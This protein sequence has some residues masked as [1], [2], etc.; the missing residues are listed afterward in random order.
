MRWCLYDLVEEGK[1]VYV[2]L[3]CRPRRRFI[4]HAKKYPGAI[5]VEVQWH[6]DQGVG[7]AAEEFRIQKLR[8]RGNTTFNVMSKERAR[9]IWCSHLRTWTN[10]DAVERMPGWSVDMARSHF[11]PRMHKLKEY[12]YL[13]GG[14]YV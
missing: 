7:R 2:G 10:A 3:S 5:G 6:G 1:T 8:P 11:G 4:E 13:S 14:N 9:K 12:A